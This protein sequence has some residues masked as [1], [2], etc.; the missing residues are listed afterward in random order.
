M[1]DGDR[2][3]WWAADPTG[4][5]ELRYWDGSEWTAHVSDRG[6]VSADPLGSSTPTPTSV[7]TDPAPVTAAAPALLRP[8]PPPPTQGTGVDPR[9]AGIGAGTPTWWRSLDGLRTALVVLFACTA[10]ASVAVMFAVVNRLGVISDIEAGQIGF[11]IVQRANDA[12]DAVDLAA[13]LTLVLALATA[14]VLII[15]QWRCAKNAELLGR[16]HPRFGPGWSIGAWFIPLANFVIPVLIF[17]D[18]WRASSPDARPGEWRKERGSGLIGLWW[19]LFV[20]SALT[21]RLIDGDEADTLADLKRQNEVLVAAFAVSTIAAALAI[22][23]VVQL[24]RRFAERRAETPA[25]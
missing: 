24:T 22:A 23:V 14:V 11:D 16:D 12:D 8:T 21:T 5:H 17:Q 7:A 3:G 18:L 6:Q 2:N 10:A 9:P 1:T 20:V 15:W 25:V 19:A 13:G 4:R